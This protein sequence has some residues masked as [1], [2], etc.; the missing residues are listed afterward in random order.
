MKKHVP[1]KLIDDLMDMYVEWREA[2]IAVSNAYTR[3]STVRVAER[4]SAFEEYR[5]ALDWEE[6]A[7][8]LYADR[9]DS[10]A[11]EVPRAR[12]DVVVA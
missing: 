9:V 3:W 10:V 2:C 5:A 1:S 8:A 6:L 4:Q 7:S 12:S 11:R